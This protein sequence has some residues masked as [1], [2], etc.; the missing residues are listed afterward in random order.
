MLG[1]STFPSGTNL[2]G[3]DGGGSS[4]ANAT[5]DGC[6]IWSMSCGDTI[7]V[8]APYNKGRTL[9]HESGHYLGLRHVWGDGNCLTD[10]CND[11][12][13]AATANYVSQGTGYPYHVN[14]CSSAGA[15]NNNVDGEMFMNFMDYS[16]DGAMWMFTNDQLLRMHTALTQSTDRIGLTASANS[17]RTKSVAKISLDKSI[18][19]YPNPTVDGHFNIS[20]NVAEATNLQ[21][22]I[23]NIL[24]KLVF[25]N[26]ENSV[27]H[28]TLR[29]QFPTFEKGIYFITIIN[30]NGDKIVRK[31]VV[32]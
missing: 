11:I 18:D 30:S 19:I 14:T 16:D 24:G 1:Y 25:K 26:N 7:S 21:I 2:A 13:P 6:W 31:I 32:Q 8:A 10:Y 4:N 28:N 3:L 15:Y 17:M 22:V 23:E 5:T 27:A 29:Y 9:T 12:P 20:V